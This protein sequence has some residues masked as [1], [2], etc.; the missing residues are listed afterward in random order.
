M[1]SPLRLLASVFTPSSALRPL[2]AIFLILPSSF[3]LPR[4]PSN[5][6]IDL[7]FEN[8]QGQLAVL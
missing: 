6:V 2:S 7:F 3:L 4:L 8:L 5:I 1:E